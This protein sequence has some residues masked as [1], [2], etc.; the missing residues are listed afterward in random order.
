[1]LTQ[2]RSTTRSGPFDE[3]FSPAFC[4]DTDYWHRA[5]QLGIELSPVPAARV[6]HARR[7]TQRRSTTTSMLLQ[8]HRYKYGWKHGVDPLRAPPYYNREIVDYVG[9]FRVPDPARSTRPAPGLRH[10]P[11]QDRHVLVP[12]GDEIL[13][14]ESLH[15]GGPPI[16]RLVEASVGRRR[17]AALA[18][19]PAL[20]RLLRHPGA[21]RHFEL[22]DEQY[23]GSRFV[24]TVRPLD[25]WI[26]SRRRHVEATS[27]G[28]PPGSTTARSWRSTR[29]RGA[30]SGTSTSTRVRAY[31]A[32]R[33]DFLEIDLGAEPRWEPLCDA[34]RS[35]EPAKPFP[36][37]NRAAPSKE[38]SFMTIE[39]ARAVIDERP[40]LHVYRD[41]SRRT[42][43]STAMGERYHGDLGARRTRI[44]ETGTG[45]TTLLFL[46]LDPGRDQRVP[47]P[48]APRP[49]AGG[50]STTG[51]RPGPG[52]VRRRPV[53]I[54]SPAARAGRGSRARCRF[55]DGNHGWPAVFIDFCY[56]NRMLRP[57]GLMFI[58][59]V[60]VSW[61]PS[62]LPASGAAAPLR[63]RRGR[64]ED[65]DLPQ[66]PRPSLAPRLADGAVHHRQHRHGLTRHRTS[67]GR[68]T[69]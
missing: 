69:R 7:T 41:G 57:G 55:I 24:L 20:R 32:G 15:W 43:A 16:R 42:G 49:H 37:V 28:R 66:S 2:G 29:R 58:D 59:D 46:S 39:Q 50:G 9:T 18:A 6:V 68:F 31:F 62:S 64:L 13:G 56:L 27:S 14:Y 51:H 53:R 11:Q 1:M 54:G 30:P 3:W 12:R 44:A 25:D 36:W 8:A 52:P 26:D 48:R 35:P 22:L 65:G 10:R 34:P 45:L 19:R 47:C 67:C 40:L 4:E 23:P 33:D 63:V 21:V 5:W 17:A 60:Q 61:S 38:P